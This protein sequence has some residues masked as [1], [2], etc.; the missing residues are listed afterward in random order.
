MILVFCLCYI[1]LL[2]GFVS[3]SRGLNVMFLAVC[4]RGQR[5]TSLV[6]GGL[7]NSYAWFKLFAVVLSL[8]VSLFTE[9]DV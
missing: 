4:Y 9:L 2:G 5:G 8:L 1:Y 7:R 6:S 3:G